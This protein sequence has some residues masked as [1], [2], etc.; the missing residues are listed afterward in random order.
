MRLPQSHS[1]P[2]PQKLRF[3]LP[4]LLC[5]QVINPTAR[6]SVAPV[7]DLQRAGPAELVA[8]AIS[9]ILPV[10]HKARKKPKLRW[11]PPTARSTKG[12]A[13]RATFPA[14]SLDNDGLGERGRCT[15]LHY[16][17]NC[18]PPLG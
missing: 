5:D 9:V 6:P 13:A 10:G 12:P 4:L 11:W 17:I 8:H 1:P 15:M 18:T 7:R 14:L 3:R 16:R 2:A